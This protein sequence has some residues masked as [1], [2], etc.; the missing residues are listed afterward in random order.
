MPTN[1][2]NGSSNLPFS[3]VIIANTNLRM[4]FLRD[5]AEKTTNLGMAFVQCATSRTSSSLKRNPPV[6][7]VAWLAPRSF[8]DT[9]QR[10][11]FEYDDLLHESSCV[12]MSATTSAS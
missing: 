2:D 11:E 6:R 10:H 4:E 5:Y 7:R 12:R 1:H 8:I 3:V 9:A